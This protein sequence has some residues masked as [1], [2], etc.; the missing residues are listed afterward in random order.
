MLYNHLWIQGFLR[1]VL[2]VKQNA[3]QH[4]CTQQVYATEKT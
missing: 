4:I 3:A 1:T 2:K